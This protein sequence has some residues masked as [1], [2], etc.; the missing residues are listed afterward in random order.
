VALRFLTGG[1]L[2][3]ALV[4]A[5]CGDG[6]ARGA[7]PPT[8]PAATSGA[9]DYPPPRD[10]AWGKFHSKRFQ[11]TIPLPD[12]RGWKIDDHSQPELE[13][14]HAPTDARLRVLATQEEEL[15]NRDRCEARAR[16][17]GWVPEHRAPR[18]RRAD[19]PPPEAQPTLTTVEDKIETGPEA[20]DSRVWV[21]ID[22]GN[23]DGPV[24]G[25]V[26]LFGAFLRRCLLVDYA[27][28][29]P[30]PK[31]EAVLASRLAIAGARIVRGIAIDPPRTTDSATIPRDKP[32][33]RR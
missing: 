15:M 24:E 5:G 26:F 9:I 7:P 6:A 33:V 30:S 22:P 18:R 2:L 4:L 10:G 11:L 8:R 23:G 28:R 21:A 16:E 13:A 31:D 27:T 17:L 1:A 25:H 14:V 20:Y 19:A 3:L 12:G 32:D 29:V